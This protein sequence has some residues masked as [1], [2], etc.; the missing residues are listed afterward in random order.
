MAKQALDG[1]KVL[2]ITSGIAGPVASRELANHGATVVHIET[3]VRR[4]GRRPP[5]PAVT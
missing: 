3:G 1:V 2:D 4:S 5:A